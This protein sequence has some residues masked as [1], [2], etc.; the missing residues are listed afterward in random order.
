MAQMIMIYADIICDFQYK[1]VR[2]LAD[3]RYQRSI[4]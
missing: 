4:K 3:Q 1:L 2:P